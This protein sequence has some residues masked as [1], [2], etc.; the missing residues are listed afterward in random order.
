MSNHT[1]IGANGVVGRETVSAL[2]QRGESVTAVGRSAST[3]SGVTSV[4]ADASDAAS[5][6]RA[7]KGAD[8]AYLTI[9][10]EYSAKVWARDWPVIM[11]NTIAA[12]IANSARLVFLDNVYAYGKVEGPMTESSPIAPSSAKGRIRAGLLEQLAAASD[13]DYTVA[14][15]ADFYGPGATTSVFNSMAIDNVAAGKSPVWML[16]STQPHSLTY[17]PDV[18]EALALLG[19]STPPRGSVWH[20]P[21]APALTGAQYLALVGGNKPPKTMSALTLKIGGIFIPAARE[22]LELTYQYTAPYHFDSS[23]FEKEYSVSP[24]P[25]DAGIA[26][27]L[28]YAQGTSVSLR[29]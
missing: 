20:V 13:L 21:T 7:L 15:A 8:V 11:A 24:T 16:D 25:Y 1:I 14:R 4:I 27:S 18:G 19:T 9:G 5:L 6:H 22:S 23:A 29:A 17:T 3:M 2:L 28:D 26:L 10:L 12:C